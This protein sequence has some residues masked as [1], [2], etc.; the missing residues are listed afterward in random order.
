V[1]FARP[2]TSVGSGA[3]KVVAPALASGLLL[4]GA[5]AIFA[6][7]SEADQVSSLQAQAKNVA[8]QLVQEQLQADAYQ[9][10]YSVTSAQVAADQ[11]AVASTQLQIKG[12][13]RQ[14]DKS[15]SQVRH[16]A[17]ESYVFNGAMAPTSGASIFGEDTRTV[18][19]A[20]EY[21]IITIGNLN[22]AVAEL[23]TAQRDEQS[24]QAVL[25]RQSAKDR[26]EQSTQAS[27]LS[28]ANA[29]V[30]HL[31]SEQAQVTGQLA[32]AVAQQSAS[33]GR[34]AVAAVTT[35]QK[36]TVKKSGGTATAPASGQ[37]APSSNTTD[38]ALNPFLQC[39]VQA[40]SGGDYQ[41][42]SPNGLYRGAFQFSQATWN[43]AAQA[44]GRPDLVGVP[45]N[46]ASK[47]DQDT[48]AVA[49]YALDGERPWLGDRCSQ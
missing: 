49:L 42:V 1:H 39:V 13:R 5:L 44:A 10:L 26:A 47:A 30:T 12:D 35:A 22:E 32:L 23:H 15:R 31:K 25:V 27:S 34:A 29:A 2:G 41:A 20:N 16:L 24:Q 48:L 46:Q 7:P 19:S 6:G 8:Q 36:V 43:F 17:V 37:P 45:P 40:E 18:Q 21:A 11:R 14:I 9:Q 38:P 28:D 33:Q 3:R 4:T